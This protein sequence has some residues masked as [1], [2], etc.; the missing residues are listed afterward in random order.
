LLT[1]NHLLINW[2]FCENPSY[3][4]CCYIKLHTNVKFSDE[5]FPSI[6][7]EIALINSLWNSL[8]I[9]RGELSSFYPS[10]DNTSFNFLNKRSFS[11]GSNLDMW[12]IVIYFVKV[13]L[14]LIRSAFR[15]TLLSSSNCF[16]LF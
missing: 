11:L 14:I 8:A 16:D 12:N 4:K 7:L 10:T 15:L 3:Y 1:F 6:Q 13:S 2:K 5:L 9:K